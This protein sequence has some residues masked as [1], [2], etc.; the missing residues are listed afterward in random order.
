[1]SRYATMFD[2]LGGEG[3]FGAFLMLGDPD[4]ET[5]A[6][7]LDEVIDVVRAESVVG[8]GYPYALETADQ[9]AVISTAD[10]NIFLRALQG[11]AS[12]EKLNFSVARKAASKERRR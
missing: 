10:R 12:R 6:R 2:R 5:S 11:L 1:M 3:A 9:A 8:L 7:L 4:L